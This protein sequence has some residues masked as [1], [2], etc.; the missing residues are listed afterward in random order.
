MDIEELESFL[1]TLKFPQ[2]YKIVAD[3]IISKILEHLNVLQKVGVSYLSLN[4]P[5][6]TLSGGEAQRVRLAGQI[7]SALIGV[8]YIFDEPSIGLHPADHEVLLSLIQKIKDRQNT[9]LMVEHDE[10]SIRCADHIID[11]GPGAGRL[12]GKLVFQGELSSIL[13]SKKSLTGDYLSKRKCIEVPQQRRLGKK[14]LELVGVCGNNLKNIHFKIPLSTLTCVTG[15]SGSGKSSLV[16][17]TLYKALSQ[18][19]YGRDIQSLAYERLIGSKEID[20]VIVVDQ[21]PIGKTSRSVP[22]TYVGV[23]SL[24]RTFMSLLPAS[25]VRGYGAG[26]FSF[27]V[28]GGRCDY[29]EGAGQIR[30]GN[31]FFVRCCYSL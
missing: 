31:A 1:K 29:C 26:H 22:A 19:I 9:I 30:Q 7:S 4:R 11:I 18:K 10:Q 27:N 8:L 17:D 24:I 2:R 13:K 14:F 12:G 25:K 5:T 23:M 20:K 16:V 6:R 21:K 3:K 28:K 15:V